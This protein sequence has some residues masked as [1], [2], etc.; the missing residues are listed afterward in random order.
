MRT[1][2]NIF[3]MLYLAD[4]TLSLFD[5]LLSFVSP[6]PAL[7]QTRNFLAQIVML[8]AFVLFQC[9][10]IDQ[11]LP[12]RIFVPLISFLCLVPISTLMFPSL[13]GPGF[14]LAAATGQLLLC[15]LPFYYLRKMNQP[16]FLL[17]ESMFQGP[18]FSLKNTAVFS[19]VGLVVLPLVSVLLLLSS[20]N[21]F[22]QENTA[23]F[24]RVAPQGLYMAD[25]V[26]RRD[27]KTI[28]LVGMIHIGEKKYY[29]ELVGQAAPGRTIILAEGVSDDKNLLPNKLD[30]GK[31]ADYLGLTLQQEKMH[32][33]AR[34]IEASE[35]EKKGAKPRADA[36]PQVDMLRADVDVSSFKPQ[37]I[38]FLAELGKH[39]KESASMA[40]SILESDSI[41]GKYFT[42]E[43]QQVV[44]GDI[45]YHRNNELVRHLRKAVQ[46]YDTIVIP[47]GALHMPG[48]EEEVLKQGFELQQTRER[49]SIDFGKLL[50]AQYA[51]P[52][53]PQ[54]SR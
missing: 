46:H 4:G 9:L 50:K 40:E 51:T 41:T 35:L 8:L 53:P 27:D 14:G 48:I 37:T 26:Y 30:Y 52:A 29:D 19:L 13:G 28:R 47:W 12:K 15:L 49:M 33:N 39:M 34:L 43:M 25:K 18:F 31:V 42:P 32:F 45:L 38:E 6:L 10:G 44:M 23:S 3:L 20:A 22:L 16:G 24:M 54:S 36:G 5:E 7:T 21:G 11:R 2:A 17:P 1:L